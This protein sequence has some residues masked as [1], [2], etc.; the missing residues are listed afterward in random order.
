MEFVMAG[1]D[2]TEGKEAGNGEFAPSEPC[3][4]HPGQQRLLLTHMVNEAQGPGG[5]METGVQA[6]IQVRQALPFLL[7][8]V[9]GL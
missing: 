8:A 1:L 6:V 2:M 7:S 4:T 3:P 5:A 9:R